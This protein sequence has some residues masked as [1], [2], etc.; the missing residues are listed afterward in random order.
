[1]G[2][3]LSGGTLTA[4]S[5]GGDVGLLSHY[6]WYQDN[7]ERWSRT[8]GLVRP[9]PRGLLDMHGNVSSGVTIGMLL[10]LRLSRS[11][12]LVQ[13]G[14]NRVYRG[15]SWSVGQFM[16]PNAQHPPSAFAKNAIHVPISRLVPGQLVG[17]KT[18][19]GSWDTSVERT[20]MPE[21]AIYKDRQTLLREDEIRTPRQP[22]VAAPTGDRMLRK[23][24]ISRSSVDRFPD[25]RMRDMTSERFSRS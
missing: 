2:G 15:G 19:V 11:I 14:S 23:M 10:G 16:L 3:G 21:T 22:P 18:P 1:M 7:S 13:R 20:T 9:N 8:V 24:A 6:G 4:Y 17:P 5:F 25:P 12:L